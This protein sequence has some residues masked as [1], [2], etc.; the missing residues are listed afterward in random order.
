MYTPRLYNAQ[1]PRFLC[2][3]RIYLQYTP[4]VIFY[5][6]TLFWYRHTHMTFPPPDVQQV[7]Q[8]EICLKPILKIIPQKWTIYEDFKDWIC[9]FAEQICTV[10]TSHMSQM[11]PKKNSPHYYILSSTTIHCRSLPYK[12]VY[13]A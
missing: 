10:K 2:T 8:Q 9:T 4:S 7:V 1:M 13:K 6:H 11:I 3:V 12:G 5:L